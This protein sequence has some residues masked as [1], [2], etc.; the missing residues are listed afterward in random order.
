M[1]RKGENI[2]KRKDGRWE[3][4]Y[5]KSRSEAGKAQYG[6]IYAKSYREIKKKLAQAINAHENTILPGAAPNNQSITFQ[7]IAAEWF[8]LRQPQVK[9]STSIKYHNLLNSYMLPALGEISLEQLS[10]EY[11]ESYCNELLRTGGV[12]KDGLSP[13]T[14]SDIL[15]IMRNIFKYAENTGRMTKCNACSI[16]IK[17]VDKE[18]RILSCNEQERL[19]QYLYANQNAYNIGILICLFTGLRIGEI[20]ALQW[21]DVSLAEQTIYVHQTMQRIQTPKSSEKKTKIMVTTPKSN[22]SIRTIPLPNGLIEIIANF[23]HSSSG[24]FLTGSLQTFVEPRTMQNH[25]QRVL[26]KCSIER[27]NYHVLRHTFA[28]RCIEFGFDVKS[29]SEILGHANVNIT[30]NKYVHPSL[31]LKRKNMQRLSVLF[32]VK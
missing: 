16:N 10:H 24:F 1:S 30:M 22:C 15:S 9:E 23:N 7:T 13:K 2:Y 17:Q 4:R 28:T 29:L 11:V 18:M 25:F 14:I 6:Y 32:T 26:E 12:K 5:I 3:G 27:V 8:A 21:E 19:C 31:E 20:C